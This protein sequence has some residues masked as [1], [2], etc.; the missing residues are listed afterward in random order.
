MSIGTP[1][2]IAAG[3]SGSS[4]LNIGT[5]AAIVAGNLVVVAIASNNSPSSFRTVSSI[6][7]GTN[8]YSKAFSFGS[9]A[10]GVELWY[11]ANALAVSSGATIAIHLSGSS[12]NNAVA[13]AAQ[14]SGI[15]TVSPNDAAVNA[16]L[17]Q[18]GGG[19]NH[20]SLTSGT[21]AVASE[22]IFGVIGYGNGSLVY[23]DNSPFA[24]VGSVQSTAGVGLGYRI[25][26]TRATVTYAPS[27]NSTPDYDLAIVAGFEGATGL[28]GG[29]NMPMLGM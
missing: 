3:S 14:I 26:S 2:K 1:T 28:V 22:I 15:K 13:V 10:T 11:V 23:S 7:D 20:P 12:A 4:T 19:S 29:F 25:I 27:F 8:T 21:P 18:T 16:H 17:D 5:T 9:S 6:S 24:S